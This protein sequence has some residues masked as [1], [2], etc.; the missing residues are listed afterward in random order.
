M[1]LC[2]NSGICRICICQWTK[3]VCVGG[4]IDGGSSNTEPAA[5]ETVAITNLGYCI[6]RV[7]FFLV[8]RDERI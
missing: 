3:P 7:K 1:I 5:T 4:N 6:S 2:I 8:V